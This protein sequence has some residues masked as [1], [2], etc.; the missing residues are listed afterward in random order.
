M[1]LSPQSRDLSHCGDFLWSGTWAPPAP[2]QGY[3]GQPFPCRVWCFGKLVL[4]YTGQR[5]FSFSLLVED[6]VTA[7]GAASLRGCCFPLFLSLQ[8]HLNN[9][10]CC[11]H[12]LKS[13][14][15][16]QITSWMFIMYILLRGMLLAHLSGY[17]YSEFHSI[18][19][20]ACST[21]GSLS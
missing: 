17:C 5:R 7:S 9:G 4:L 13:P 21:E 14:K 19:V 6:H 1:L 12:H 8:G 15:D 3:S 10:W 16:R 20:S 18:N 11:S 2:G